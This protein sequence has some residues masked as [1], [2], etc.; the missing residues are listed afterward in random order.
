MNLKKLEYTLKMINSYGL[1]IST[2]K[3]S[4]NLL[5]TFGKVITIKLKEYLY[6]IYV[7]KNGSDIEVFYEVLV[8][9]D[10]RFKRKLS[11]EPQ[12]IV[13]CGAN[14]GLA[15]VYFKSKY[16]EST[17]IAIEPEINN[18]NMLVNNLKNYSDI[19]CLNLGIWSRKANI[20]VDDSQASDYG[21]SFHEVDDHVEDAV[22]AVSIKNII[23]QYSLDRIDILKVDIEGAEL[24]LFK[25]NYDDWLPFVRV[26]IIELHDRMRAGCSKALFDALSK[27]NFSTEIRGENLFVFLK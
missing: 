24:E 20:A 14:I 5:F 13:D 4:F 1:N 9:Q 21:F 17:I 26:L 2:I 27:Y 19:H 15:S 12:V 6:P 8:K 23:E 16:P 10:Y 25:N 11:F 18:Y 22:K 3:S 7:R